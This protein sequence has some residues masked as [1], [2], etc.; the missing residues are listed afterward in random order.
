MRSKARQRVRERITRDERIYVNKMLDLVELLDQVLKEK[1]W[2]QKDLANALG[3]Q[4][5]EI[6][7]WL[8]GHN[9][10]I[11]TLSKLEAVLD[12]ELMSVNAPAEE[13]LVNV[14]NYEGTVQSGT[15]WS[16]MLNNRSRRPIL[17]F[18]GHV[19]TQYDNLRVA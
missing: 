15:D 11:R 3:K 17:S 14:F 8:N 2:S 6:S 12:C 9:L 10:T 4:P 7:K 16:A 5:S 1:E 19:E 13:P 18:E